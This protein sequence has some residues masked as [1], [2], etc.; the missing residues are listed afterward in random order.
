MKSTYAKEADI[1]EALKEH[2]TEQGAGGEW[3][4]NLD[5]DHPAVTSVVTEA[6][7][8]VGEFRNNNIAK[9]KALTEALAKL[10]TFKDISPEAYATAQA[11]ITE[12]EGKQKGM[13]GQEELQALIAAA[14]KPVTE[15]LATERAARETAV[16]EG[17]IQKT[18][19]T[20]TAAGLKAGV[21]EGAVADFLSRGRGVFALVD[22]QLQAQKDGQPLYSTK[23][24]GE[25]L[26]V[27]EW[28]SDLQAEA[29]H[30][31]KDSSGGGAGGGG[32]NA[33]DTRTTIPRDQMKHNL[34]AVAS[35]EKKVGQ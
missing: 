32:N 30:L 23:R 20:L 24:P 22:G 34:E 28:A 16:R 13:K 27:D 11:K 35:G 6:N 5:S 15:A 4:L 25:F 26:T 12:L 7:K 2:Y 17:N 9:D 18:D 10:E 1:P 14:L 31:Y 21:S 8:K 3:V 29:P 19:G 33:G